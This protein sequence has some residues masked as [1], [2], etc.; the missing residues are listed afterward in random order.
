MTE[1]GGM[2]SGGSLRAT[3]SAPVAPKTGAG[4]VV[5]QNSAVGVLVQGRIG[6]A[7]RDGGLVGIVCRGTILIV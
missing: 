6:E 3:V 1:A 2:V 7:K 4:D 5:D